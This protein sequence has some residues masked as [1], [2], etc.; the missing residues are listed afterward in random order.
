MS[1]SET[2]LSRPIPDGDGG[3]CLNRKYWAVTSGIVRWYPC[4]LIHALADCCV[5]WERF[6]RTV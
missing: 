3:N 6:S 4:A 1:P 2:I 5:K